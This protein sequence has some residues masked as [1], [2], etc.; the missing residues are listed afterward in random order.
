MVMRDASSTPSGLPTTRPTTMPQKMGER[1]A[2]RRLSPLTT[3][4]ALASANTGTM[5]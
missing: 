4:P 1:T 2:S 5:T 3:T